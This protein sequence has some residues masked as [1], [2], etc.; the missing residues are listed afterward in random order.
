M[1]VSF[2]YVTV[3]NVEG[4]QTHTLLIGGGPRGETF[5]RRVPR[6]EAKLDDLEKFL[7]MMKS[8][9]G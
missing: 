2:D 8:R 4:T 9:Y 1:T 3:K 6:K 5:A 7:E